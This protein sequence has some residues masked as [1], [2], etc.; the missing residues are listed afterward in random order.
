MSVVVVIFFVFLIVFIIF[1]MLMMAFLFRLHATRP[2][3]PPPGGTLGTEYKF[4]DEGFAAIDVGA[5]PGGW[6]HQ[7][8]KRA[9]ARLVVAIDPAELSTALMDDPL[10]SGA[11]SRTSIRDTSCCCH[12]LTGVPY[13]RPGPRRPATP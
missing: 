13:L 9:E 1:I 2:P 4:P 8:L 7:L 10:A 11:W 5:A 12:P 6:T 3:S